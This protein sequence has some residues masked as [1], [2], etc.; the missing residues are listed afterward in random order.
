M[1]LNWKTWLIVTAA[2]LGLLYILDARVNAKAN[3]TEQGQLTFDV[4]APVS[5][6]L[7]MALRDMVNTG[8]EPYLSRETNPIQWL[9]DGV[10]KSGQNIGLDPLIGRSTNNGETPDPLMTFEGVPSLSGVTPP[11]TNGD[12]GPNN[13]IQM[14]NFSFEIWNKGDPINGIPP[15]SLLGPITTAQFFNG[16]GDCANNFG[17]PVVLYDDLA[18]RWLISQFNLNSLGMC[19]AISTGSDPLG[20]Y[21]MYNIPTPDF[22]D[23]PKL[24]VWPDAYLMGTNTGF[25]NQYYAHAFDRV[26]ML[27][28]APATR[29]SVGGL[30]NLPMPADVDGLVTPPAGDP[31]IFYTYYHPDGAGHPAGVP[32]I[33]IFEYDLDWN[34]PGNSTFNT[35]AELPVANFNYT[36]CGFFAGGCIQQPG[37]GQL[38]D[39]IAWWPMNRFQ[40][41]NFGGYAAMV[42]NF[43]VDA[44]G[45]NH[46]GIRWFEIH[47]TAGTYSLYQEGTYA[48]DTD[49]RWMGSIAMD[50]SGNIALG[51]SVSSN[52]TIPSI[53]YATRQAGDPLGTLND[54][55]VMYPGGGVQTSIHRWGD[56]SSMMVDPTDNCTF[57]FTTEYHDTNDSGFGWNTRIGAF[58]IPSCGG[59]SGTLTGQVTDSSNSQGIPGASVQATASITKTGYTLTDAN[60]FYT[61]TLL[62]GNYY[63]TATAFAYLPDSISGVNIV[64]GTVETQ[65]F[66][67][68]PAPT[69]V[70]EGVVT[71]DTTGWPLYA[72]IDIGGGYPSGL[73]WTNPETGYYSVE[74]PVGTY[75]FTIDAFVDGYTPQTTNVTVST[76]GP[77]AVTTS[78]CSNTVVGIPDNTPAGVNSAQSI[79]NTGTLTDVN[80]Q[81]NTTHTWVGDLI[82]TLTHNDT[83]TSVI[84]FDRPGVPAAG[85]GCSGDNLPDIVLDDD[86]EGA[87]G[88]PVETSC[89][90]INPA[91]T[92][93]GYYTPNNPLS[94]F[95][96]QD[97]SGTWTVNVSDNAGADTG[98]LNNWCLSATVQSATQTANFSLAADPVACTAPGYQFGSGSVYTQDF[99]ANDGGFTVSGTTTWAWG[100]PTSG[101]GSAH[102]GSNAWATNLSGAYN[103]FEDGYI[104]SPV[105]DLSA[106]AGNPIIF[107]WWQWLQT[108][109]GF[110]Y[111]SVEV[112]NNGGTSWTTVYGPIDGTV[113]SVWTEHSVLLNASYAVSNFQVRFHFTSD[114]SVTFPG[115]YVDD[116]TISSGSCDPQVGGL[117][118]GNVY[119]LNT[120]DPV[121][122]AWVTNTAGETAYGM[123]TPLDPAVD[124][125]FYT[126][127]SFGGTQQ[128]VA[129]YDLYGED[130]Q[131][132]N[133]VNGSTVRQDFNL[134]SGFV[135]TDP[136]SFDVTLEMGSNT[137]LPFTLTDVGGANV[138]FVIREAPGTNP[139]ASSIHIP[140]SDGNFP[141]GTSPL[142]MGPAPVAG[143]PSV[144]HS[145]LAQLLGSSAYSIDHSNLFYTIFDVDVPEV[146]PNIGGM[147][148]T[149]DFIGAGEY[150]NGLVYMVD[151]LNNMWEVDGATGAILNTYTATPPSGGTYSG[152]ALDP[153][154]GVLYA[155]ATDCSS[156]SLY[157]MDAPT[158]AATLIGPVTNGGCLIAIAIDGNGDLWGYDIISDMF[159]WIDKTTGAGTVIGSIGFDANFGQGMGWDPATD[160][161][162]MAAFNS[163]TFVPELR[164]VDRTTGNTTLIGVLGQ[165]DPGGL[166]QLPWLGFEIAGGGD[167]PWVSE[168][169][170]TG[171]IP[172]NGDFGVD[173][174]FDA[175]QVP[176][177]GQ[178]TAFLK[179]GVDTPQLEL[180]IPLTLT[181]TCPTC[182]TAEGSITD[183]V[184]GLPI[185]SSVQITNTT[186]YDFTFEDVTD[187]SVQLLPGEYFITASATGYLSET[188]TVN[189]TTGNTVTKDFALWAN[190]SLLSFS[191]ASV[192]ETLNI[193][194]MVTNTV[195]ITN[196]GAASMNY[197]VNI[198][199]YSGPFVLLAQTEV[200]IPRFTG[201]VDK[202]DRPLSA[203][204]APET[205]KAQIQGPTFSA[206][207]GEQAYALDVYPGLNL[208][209]F[210][211]A[212]VPGTMNVVGSVPQ[213]HPAGDFLNGD[214]STLYALDYDT[215]EFVAIDTSTAA[216]TVLG[217]T[218]PN[219]NWS[220][221]T[222]APDGTLY[223]VSSVCGSSSTLYTVDPDDGTLTTVGEIGS[224]TCI[225]DIAINAEGEMYGVDIV[226]D[227]LYAIDPSTGAG[228]VVGS[229]GVDAN[230]A[231]GMDFEENSGILYWAAY[232]SQGEMRVIDTTTGASAS[233][234][235]FAGGAEI[236]ALAF[237]T[238]GSGGLGGWAYAVPDFGTLPPFSTTTFQLVFDA[239][240]LYQTG[241]YYAELSFDG[242][243]AND[244]GTMPLTMHVNCPTCGFLAG[245]IYDAFTTAPVA[246][247]VFIS[248]DSG[249]A[250]TLTNVVSYNLALQ[251]GTYDFNVTADGYFGASATVTVE[252]GQTVVTD[253]AL[254]PIVAILEYSPTSFEHT[255]V[256]DQVLTDTL[257]LYNTGTTPFEFELSDVSTGEAPALLAPKAGNILLVDDDD[258]G[259]DVLGYYTDALDALGLS[260]DVWDTGGTDNEPDATTLSGYTTV[261]W[262]TGVSFGGTAGP[263]AASEAA[264]GAWLDNGACY[265][266]SSQ[267][268]VYDRGVTS[269]MTNYLGIGSAI[270]DVGQTT[271]TGQ[272]SLY[273]GLGPYSLAY[274]FTNYSDDLT[275]DGTAE[276]AFSGDATG[277]A[278]VNKTT[279]DYATTFLGYPLEAI[280]NVSDRA[281]VL[282]AFLNSCASDAPWLL[283]LPATGSVDP[284]SSTA[285]SIIFDASVITQTGT[286]TAELRF[287][288]TYDNNV[289]NATVVMHVIDNPT[290]GVEISNSVGSGEVGTTVTHTMWITNTGNYADVFDVSASGNTWAT[291]VSASTVTLDPG[292]SVAIMCYVTIPADAEDGATDT[293]SVTVTGR[294]DPAATATGTAE[295]EATVPVP[296]TFELLLP[297]VYK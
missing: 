227:S 181:V 50:I 100:T 69:A 220:G 159:L 74:L 203:A 37:T 82:F 252:Q 243:F 260:Y 76:L 29:Q 71:D 84:P 213:F 78:Y 173:V 38:L 296:P 223:A 4:S 12:V 137:T 152:M 126:I 183:I 154:T 67:L 259:P 195:T 15:T 274:P 239:R 3:S 150:V 85:A 289:S 162:Y 254:T 263:G 113:D 32:R 89:L 228:T 60:G 98:T 33:A 285:V 121:N 230:F 95:D 139:Y 91:Y 136:T 208:V 235:A 125:A 174:T 280:S 13:Y 277:N 215:N 185:V 18:D 272:G 266:I 268:Y 36:I 90:N 198:G 233:V 216:R 256:L 21:W 56:Y 112:S 81:L 160:T 65:N 114:V 258:N 35:V 120:G 105:I 264:L 146:L 244:P 68:D 163:S 200:H 7:S 24:G 31:A 129:T 83:S 157:T 118:V 206:P 141:R 123:P 149:S 226:S 257:V 297:I 58:R 167:V 292:Q 231:Q 8:K 255:V 192:E 294:F 221:M 48:P 249:T 34:N 275:P 109:S 218:S 222:G 87:P 86:G 93:N 111:A 241:D 80:L 94:A 103:D 187:Y 155:A 134:P 92:P 148:S 14:T 127:F 273:A 53:R 290:S 237:T 101:P 176:I 265:F 196:S 108:E 229:L 276:L 261:I 184:T 178:Y 156:A 44:D 191:P 2:V 124:D 115:W 17:D 245:D 293:A 238:G 232:T 99:E 63:I 278:A 188:A 247:D 262:F 202:I 130:V 177:P 116:I 6:V 242:S 286:Y 39:D 210:P 107:D 88:T 234:G 122:G 19:F 47:K 57:W 26:A 28:G 79:A 144:P 1:K 197:E 11:D 128:H 104:T 282:D 51:Y 25:P 46:A 193:G 151:G 61:M 143:N 5:P 73:I 96:G 16:V 236:D 267:D 9:G 253:F 132:V 75:P 190:T 287:N 119:D 248:S 225:I 138:E 281:A 42:G 52:T 77:E 62:E 27:A 145:T 20:S 205:T 279:N 283:E 212:D 171:T 271:V 165:T 170:I 219:G 64:S 110:D 117:V 169:P 199:G 251:P 59:P 22:P 40:Y 288:G 147:P 217:T 180:V 186:G 49:S 189:I 204:P 10:G 224:G 158:G 291:T 207:M 135:I 133:V 295:T 246:A 43:T 161:L 140:A 153:T 102:S 175:A 66:A 131:D 209:Q 142:S 72:S 41:R 240:S 269:F 23:Y 70:V 45:N 270:S 30:A 284:D 201:T 164:A 211:D 179:V 250:I 172:A 166:S 97:L 182:G 106:Y 214:F 54:E 168:T 55:A 194:D